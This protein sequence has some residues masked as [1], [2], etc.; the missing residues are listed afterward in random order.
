[1]TPITPFL[2]LISLEPKKRI[3][4]T[5]KVLTLPTNR[6]NTEE[7]SNE[8]VREQLINVYMSSIE[9]CDLII[10]G[11]KTKVARDVWHYQMEKQANRIK[12]NLS[13]TLEEF[14]N[15]K[16]SIKRTSMLLED[17]TWRLKWLEV[18]LEKVDDSDENCCEF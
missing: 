5:A 12:T 9:C 13:N 4:F 8:Q 1:M 17:Y 2:V 16:Y 3:Y 7:M 11:S 15:N 6:M 14:R 18:D 10:K